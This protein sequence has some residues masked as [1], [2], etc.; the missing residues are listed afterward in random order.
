MQELSSYEIYLNAKGRALYSNG[1]KI[2]Q[3]LAI[4]T[5]GKRFLIDLKACLHVQIC[6]NNC[7][8]D[9]KKQDVFLH[10]Q[11]VKITY[12]VVKFTQY[13]KMIITN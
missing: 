6:L 3:I 8:Y 10:S 11:T 9:V 5:N 12:N 13:F 7:L 4:A 2:D 1:N